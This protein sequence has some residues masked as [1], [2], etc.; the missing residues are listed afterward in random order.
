[1]VTISTMPFV[2]LVMVSHCAHGVMGRTLAHLEAGIDVDFS[3]P[4]PALPFA[5]PANTSVIPPDQGSG[6]AA[7]LKRW[8]SERQLDLLGLWNSM[9]SSAAGDSQGPVLFA[10]VPLAASSFFALRWIWYR[11]R[12]SEPFETPA[13]V[14]RQRKLFDDASK[15]T[16]GSLSDRSR[17]WDFLRTYLKVIAGALIISILASLVLPYL[18]FSYVILGCFAVVAVVY[19]RQVNQVILEGQKKS[20]IDIGHV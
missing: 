7:A 14:A 16:L 3:A 2:V 19:D 17:L 12:P 5:K 18:D 11:N 8:T 1:M 13:E 15:G 20:G 10:A 6:F 9:S 4:V